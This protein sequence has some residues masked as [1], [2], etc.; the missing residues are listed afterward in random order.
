MAKSAPAVLYGRRQVV[1]GL[2]CK[3]S[4]L[5]YDLLECV[6]S[7]ELVQLRHK[8]KYEVSQLTR[9]CFRLITMGH[10]PCLRSS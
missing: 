5:Y 10:F 8:F 6:G 2:Q 4:P 9:F 7:Q 1:V 3:N